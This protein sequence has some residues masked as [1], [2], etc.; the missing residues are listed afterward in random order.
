VQWETLQDKLAHV[1]ARALV[2]PWYVLGPMSPKSKDLQKVRT[3]QKLDLDAR[4]DDGS[5]KPIGWQK[6]E[7]IQDGQVNDLT[8]YGGAGKDSVVFVC[9]S[10][11][12]QRPI[13]LRDAYLDLSADNASAHWLP[14][15]QGPSVQG[16]LP[17]VPAGQNMLRDSASRQ[18]LLEVNAAPDGRR[19]FYFA[20]RP[21]SERPGGGSAG[22]RHDQRRAIYFEVAKTFSSPLDL[23]QM[24][25]DTEAGLWLYEQ[26]H[27]D[28]A[29]GLADDYLKA[30]YRQAIQQR[31]RNLEALLAEQSGVKAMVVAKRKDR[32]Q[33]WAEQA[34]K[35]LDA[36]ADAARLRNAYYQVAAVQEAIELEARLCS[37]RLAVEDHR[38]MFKDRYPK[39]QAYLDRIAAI[40]AGMDGLWGRL[41]ANGSAEVEAIVGAKQTI[42]A[43]Q[44]EIL[45]DT[46]L[47]AFDKL[48][49]AKGGA[50]FNSNWGGPKARP[51]RSCGVGTRPCPGKRRR[52]S[53]A[54]SG[55][56]AARRPSTRW[57]PC[58]R[59]RRSRL[60][61]G[62]RA[63]SVSTARSSPCSTIAAWAPIRPTGARAIGRRRTS[64]SNGARST[65]SSMPGSTIAMRIRCRCRRS[66]P[67]SRR[68]L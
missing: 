38:Q 25:W 60:G 1:K 50:G 20:L 17:I 67:T 42:D 14:D 44:T 30:K 47:L 32:L 53:A 18:L 28:W 26:H 11:G 62:R 33:A 65:K 2:G 5:G 22:K 8:T 35:S 54:T 23:M 39:G 19:R 29:P 56:T 36:P 63:V 43:A 16:R 66:R 24:R 48:L 15:R 37:M 68:S 49:L 27:E 4:Y 45:L 9:R 58:T 40:E 51:S 59:R 13:T 3:A 7:Q 12:F 57:P 6:C 46:P 52:A 64:R 41:L 31:L 61:T 21:S 34:G 10:I 55:R